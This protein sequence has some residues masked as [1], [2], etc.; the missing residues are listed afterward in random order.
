MTKRHRELPD[1]SPAQR[2]IMVIVWDRG[3][4]SARE[5]REALSKKRDVSR[6]TVRTLIERME[7]KGWITH[8][9]DGRTHLM[10]VPV[11]E[12]QQAPLLA[13]I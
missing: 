4:V 3:E 13:G 1:L 7:A 10:M 5:V 8:R 11:P 9:E 12:P 6:N 2:E